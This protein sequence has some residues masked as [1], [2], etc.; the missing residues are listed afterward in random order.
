MIDILDVVK[1]LLQYLAG[2]IDLKSLRRWL[3][4]A[5]V[6]QQVEKRARELLHFLEGQYAEFS[7]GLI[8]ERV[9]K[10]G[11]RATIAKFEARHTTANPSHSIWFARTE[12]QGSVVQNFQAGGSTS[13]TTSPH[14]ELT[15]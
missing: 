12:Q 2:D 7:D 13:S 5:D 11:F 6:C 14:L 3:V 8:S 1:K 9:L 4:D 15:K 10:E